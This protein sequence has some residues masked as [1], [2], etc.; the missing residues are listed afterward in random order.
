VASCWIFYVKFTMMH[1]STNIKKFVY[2]IWL[3]LITVL[4]CSYLD[5]IK[6]LNLFC[7]LYI[8]IL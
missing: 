3:I 6:P 5:I 4:C 7:K 2:F 1:G 8:V